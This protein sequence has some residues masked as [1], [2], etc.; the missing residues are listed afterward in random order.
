MV[1]RPSVCLSVQSAYTQR[2]S[3]GAGRDGAS[4]HFRPS[5]T[6]TDLG[7]TCC[8]CC[9]CCD[10]T[11]I[12]LTADA[13]CA[14]T[15]DYHATNGSVTVTSPATDG[16]YVL[17][18]TIMSILSIIG[19]TLL[20]V[21][22]AAFRDLRSAG[23]RLLTWLSVADCLTAVGNLLGVIWYNDLLLRPHY[24]CGVL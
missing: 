15:D 18:T 12:I 4:V 2:D 21:A 3:Q 14:S 22:D 5:I 8:C 10:L 17:L 6:R 24:Y 7:P 16:T 19:C 9:C 1:W 11:L 13:M 20:I 23:R